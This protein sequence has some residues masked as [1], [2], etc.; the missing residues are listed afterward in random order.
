MAFQGKLDSVSFE[1][2]K[3]L[4]YLGVDVICVEKEGIVD[5]LVHLQQIL[6]LLWC[7]RRVSYQS[8]VKC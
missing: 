2:Y 4:A 3:Q 6:V 8:M 7:N 5:K 1:N